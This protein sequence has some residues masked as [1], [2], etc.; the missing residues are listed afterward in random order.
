MKIAF[1]I[2]ARGKKYRK[3][4][5]QIHAVFSEMPIVLFQS[6]FARHMLEI[7][8]AALSE[9]C[10]HLIAI[11][12]D[13]TFNEMV[14]GLI[15]SFTD[16]SGLVDWYGVAQIKLGI[17]GN[18]TGNDFIRNFEKPSLLSVREHIL[19][20]KSS[21]CD[22]AVA[23]TAGNDERQ[24]THYF[25]NVADAGVGATVIQRELQIARVV[26]DSLSYLLAIVFTLPFF[27]KISLEITGDDFSWKGRS[28]TCIVANGKYFADG[29]GIAPEARLNDGKLDIVI[30]GNIG[31]IDYL[32]QLSKLKQLKKLDHPEVHYFRS[33]SLKITSSSKVA[34]ETDGEIAGLTP[35]A[36]QCLEQ[37]INLLA[38]PVLFAH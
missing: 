27:R 2:K 36:I 32:T 26:N 14:N 18:G 28:M 30:V 31:L 15:R 7:P 3:L 33:G 37:R 25:M 4:E 29:M 6:R 12:G 22:V 1:L 8:R 10:D 38:S 11:G 23:S 24:I 19:S 35:V 16:E 13:G 21:I 34:F 20:G 17:I 5:Q 9:G